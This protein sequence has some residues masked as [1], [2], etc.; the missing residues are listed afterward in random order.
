V[1][2]A[3]LALLA[4][5]SAAPARAGDREP[6][7]R[8]APASF[9]ITGSGFGH[10]VGMSQYG[11]FAMAT[12]HATVPDIIEYYYAGATVGTANNPRTDIG[13]QVLG[14][15]GDP[16]GT[17]LSLSAGQWR[18]RASADAS[19]DLAVGGPAEKIKLAVSNGKVTA[20][21]LDAG[22]VVETVPAHDAL[23]LQWTGTRAWPGGAEGVVSV[24]GAQGRYRY[25]TLTASA[26]G[27]HV[28]VVNY[29]RINDEYLYG[30][31]EM[32]SLWGS[33]S[34]G[35]FA[36][37]EA[38]A[39]V[40][41]NY[42]IHAKLANPNG[43]ASCACQVYDDTRSQ[44][45]TGWRKENG[46]AGDR[47]T[48]AVDATR[49]D[50]AS[51]VWVVRDSEGNIAETPF[52][53]RS[54]RVKGAGKGT[55]SNHD[56]FGTPQQAQLVHRPDPYSFQ[57]QPDRKYLSWTDTL[58]QAKA[59]RIFGLRQVARIEVTGRYSSGQVK[60]L[61]AVPP[62]GKAV[63]RTKTADGWRVALGVQG[64]WVAGFAPHR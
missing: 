26:I 15:A 28:N 23:V 34:M 32:P 60:T 10:G 5:T 56:V 43:I 41:R 54:G 57:A 35:G 1:A 63:S 51:T 42:A 39:I 13:V 49:Q 38:Q 14:S 59:R 8:A 3:T 30:I 33:D 31:D 61:K 17:T 11:A 64:S 20:R 2:L 52:F 45:F 29:V 7:R 16:S 48:S 62:S 9:T 19:T 12:G 40:S 22:S 53:A 27:G 37:L 4:V 6:T 18:L 58:S 46:Q 36:A 24:A 25:G 47:W 50:D 55:A 21:V 44:N